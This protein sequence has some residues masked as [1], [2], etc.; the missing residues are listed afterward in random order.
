[1]PD[2][3]QRRQQADY[4]NLAEKGGTVNFQFLGTGF[5]ALDESPGAQKKS[6]RYI[7]DSATSS[8]ITGYEPTH[9]FNVDYIQSDEAIAFIADIAK[10]RKTG[11]D[12]VREYVMV[13]LDQPVTGQD[14]SYKAR[15]EHVSIEVANFKSEDGELVLDGN[16]NAI[17]D[18][19]PGTF[20]VTSKTFT[21]DGAAP[22]S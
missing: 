3:K 18:V 7:N 8:S 13:D 12:T 1:M 4:L 19:I 11:P 14:G 15:L 20:N 22:T 17:G 6:K 21:E 16:F 5:T 2:I 10:F 9:A